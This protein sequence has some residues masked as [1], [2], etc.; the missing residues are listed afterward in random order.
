MRARP[1]FGMT[2]TQTTSRGVGTGGVGAA[3]PP[4]FGEGGG[5][6]VSPP[7]QYLPLVLQNGAKIAWF[8]PMSC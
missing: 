2:T 6:M 7:P 4:I 3:L 8:K 5:N 1:P